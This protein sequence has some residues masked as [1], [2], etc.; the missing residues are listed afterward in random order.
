LYHTPH[1]GH[2]S[3]SSHMRDKDQEVGV[4]SIIIRKAKI[5]GNTLIHNNITVSL[6][7]VD[8][9]IT[10]IEAGEIEITQNEIEGIEI[11]V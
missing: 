4:V 11:I 3:S 2:S 7:L 6:N 9:E 10:Q 5:I 8:I 1:L